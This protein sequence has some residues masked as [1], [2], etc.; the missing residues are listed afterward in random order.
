MKRFLRRTG[1]EEHRVIGIGEGRAD[2]GGPT[3][4]AVLFGDGF[5]LF[6]IAADQ[7]RVGHQPRAVGEFDAALLTDCDDRAH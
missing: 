3:L 2:I 1:I 4:D 7:D 5:D 6:R